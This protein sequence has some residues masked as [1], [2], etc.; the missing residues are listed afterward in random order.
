MSSNYQTDILE[1]VLNLLPNLMRQ[2]FLPYLNVIR[3]N[4]KAETEL[5]LK[6]HFLDEKTLKNKFDD[7]TNYYLAD[8][9]IKSSRHRNYL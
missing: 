5:I 8:F 3:N 1:I 7:L 6:S 2:K 4:L 9:N